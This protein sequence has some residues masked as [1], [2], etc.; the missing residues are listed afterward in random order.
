MKLNII[1]KKRKNIFMQL[2]TRYFKDKGI[3]S[4]S[5]FVNQINTHFLPNLRIN[6]Y[7]NIYVHCTRYIQLNVC[8]ISLIYIY[9]YLYSNLNTPIS[10]IIIQS[11]NSNPT[12]NELS[13][14]K[15]KKKIV[16]IVIY[17]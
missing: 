9:T 16:N 14:S 15:K 12:F 6:S 11:N 7:E 17:R 10:K 1:F 13:I 3:F 4:R 5:L 2:F 8:R